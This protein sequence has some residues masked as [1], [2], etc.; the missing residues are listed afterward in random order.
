MGNGDCAGCPCYPGQ[1]APHRGAAQVNALPLSEQFGKVSMVG[2]GVA[3]PGQL[4]HGSRSGLGDG[5]VGPPSSVAVGQCGGTVS[6]IGREKTLGM[7]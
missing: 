3:F 2:A 4:H 1:Y 6:A 7:A 5:V